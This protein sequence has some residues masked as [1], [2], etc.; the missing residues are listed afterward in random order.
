MA[1]H[2]LTPGA[3]GG[4]ALA[5]RIVMGSM[6]LG[7]ETQDDGGAA[8][9]AFYAE[10]ARGGASLIVTGGWA[11]SREGAGGPEYGLIGDD[12]H[13]ERLARA[14]EAV[15][16]EGGR[17]A[18]QLFHAGRYAFASSFG[19][20]PVGPSA[21]PSRFSPD[22]P[23]ALSGDE[24]EATI[25]D[26]ARGA[27]RAREA[28]CDAVEVMGSEGYLV[29]QF[30]SPLTNRR[31]DDWGGDAERRMRF[32]LA[33]VEAIRAAVG[34]GFPVI[35]RMSG[36]DLMEGS[37]SPEE[38][39]ELA[40][41]LAAA[42]VDALNVG[43]GWHESRVPTVQTLVPAGAWVRHAAAV[44]GA[45]GNLPVIASNR[46]N[47]VEHADA[48]LASGACDFVSMARP[49]LADPEIVAKA[50]RGAGR[51]VNPCIACNQACIDR[52]LLDERVSCMV[53]PR[54]GWEAEPAPPRGAG[55]MAVAGG[56]PAG[57]EA[58]RELAALGHAVVLYE[59]ADELGGQFR[60]ARTV[61]G[62]EDFGA[63]I[64]A[65][66]ARLE[67]LGVEVRLGRRLGE[68]DVGEL[69]GFDGVVV[70]TGVVPR[71]LDLP[72]ADLPHVRTYAEAF[73]EPDALGERVVIVGAGGIGVDLAHRLSHAAGEGVDAF[74]AEHG[75][76]A[77]ASASASASAW[78]GAAPPP[79]R[80]ALL[81][82]HGRVGAGM[83]RSTRWA[84]LDAL[85]RAGVTWETGVAYAAIEPGGVRLADGRLVEADSVVVAAGQERHDPLGAA[86]ARAGV[87]HRVVG[88][89]R[90]ADGADAVRAFAEGWRA[91]RD[92]ART[93]SA[94][95]R[96]P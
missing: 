19:L 85:K 12:A 36:A 34:P 93:A 22:P 39:L 27:A 92:L 11:V 5:H 1:D 45:V 20:Q 48:V 74:L 23:R 63:S 53:N 52:S 80:I 16:A 32:A 68:E 77:P 3:I 9:A 25:A 71:R 26:F 40:R 37:S 30:C 51:L 2:A 6:H 62:K 70:A 47:R 4:M 18:L 24:V 66:A 90:L 89:A 29:N 8:L 79:R 72:G 49:F 42:G 95:A 86:L 14:V 10:R 7:F 21:V 81:R 87:E 17:L 73:A 83:G 31:E 69:A 65:F 60:M 41:A 78:S 64:E 67:A 75:L 13:V 44:K 91:A 57:L 94:A 58:A 88:G 28:G 76:A 84:V 82:R 43:V 46:I 59:A 33:V 50:R 38:V 54:A 55:R 56:G 15:H 61:P 35:F 96:V